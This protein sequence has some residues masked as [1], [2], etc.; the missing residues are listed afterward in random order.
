MEQSSFMIAN[1]KSNIIQFSTKYDQECDKMYLI[2]FLKKTGLT[3]IQQNELTILM[4]NYD[5]K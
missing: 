4:F 3:I 2:L 5:L 1:Q